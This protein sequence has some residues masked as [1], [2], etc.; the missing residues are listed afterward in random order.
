MPYTTLIVVCLFV[1]ICCLVLLNFSKIKAFF[2][3]FNFNNKKSNKNKKEKKERKLKPSENQ[4]RPILKPPEE[5]KMLNEPKK[6]ENF[7][8]K[9]ESKQKTN[10]EINFITPDS[11]NLNTGTSINLSTKFTPTKNQNFKSK[12][13]LDKEFEDI[14]NFINIPVKDINTSTDANVKF[15]KAESNDVSVFKEENKVKFNLDNN[16]KQKN[17]TFYPVDNYRN[18]IDV[19]GDEID[20]NKLPLSL[21]KLLIANVLGRKDFN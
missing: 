16:L 17:E 18:I 5:V 19:D 10:K 11:I 3:K 2:L 12:E 1:F 20:L 21:R 7:N 15:S 14:K 4:I 9:I 6:E 8:K 13:E